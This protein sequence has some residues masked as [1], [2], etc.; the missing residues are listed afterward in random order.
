ML[1]NSLLNS[2]LLLPSLTTPLLLI[3]SSSILFLIVVFLVVV[4]DLGR[5]VE[6]GG[7]EVGEL[8]AGGAMGGGM[9]VQRLAGL[10]L[11]LLRGGGEREVHALEVHELVLQAVQVV[12]DQLHGVLDLLEAGRRGHHRN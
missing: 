4:V 1:Q 3:L 5:V 8:M 11:G 12:G 9:W 2:F 6:L 7:L 10:V